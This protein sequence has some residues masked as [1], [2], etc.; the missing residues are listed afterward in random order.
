[1]IKN[2]HKETTYY[3]DLVE[4]KEVTECRTDDGECIEVYDDEE[5]FGWTE[6]YNLDEE[7]VKA[8]KMAILEEHSNNLDE[9]IK[10]TTNKLNAL[11]TKRGIKKL[12]ANVYKERK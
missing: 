3:F 7:I 2:I 9:E 8:V 11:E 5:G 4:G 1:M 10:N 6:M 12:V